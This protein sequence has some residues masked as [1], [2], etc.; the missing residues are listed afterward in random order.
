MEEPAAESYTSRAQ[1]YT[2]LIMFNDHAK[3]Y[4]NNAFLA[5]QKISPKK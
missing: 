3:N 1:C 5:V 4:M 2:T